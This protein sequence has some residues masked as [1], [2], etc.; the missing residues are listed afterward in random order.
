M[1]SSCLEMFEES[2]KHALSSPYRDLS[3]LHTSDMKLLEWRWDELVPSK[4]RRRGEERRGP[5]VSLG[6]C[7]DLRF[8]SLVADW[9]GTGHVGSEET[10]MSCD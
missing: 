1:L 9:S 4:A 6:V 10:K 8:P 3:R 2:M 5:L 7:E